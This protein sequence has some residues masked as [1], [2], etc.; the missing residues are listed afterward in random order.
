M[1]IK[2]TERNRECDSL[3]EFLTSPALSNN[4]NNKAIIYFYGR[5]ASRRIHFRPQDGTLKQLRNAGGFRV[6]H[7]SAVL[8]QINSYE[9]LLTMNQENKEVEEKELTEYSSV[10]AKVF[11]AKIF[12]EMATDSTIIKPAGSPHSFPMILSC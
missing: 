9:L 11:S 12:Q 10:A 1:E 8:S 6:V 7:D 5:N 2:R 4:N 3:I